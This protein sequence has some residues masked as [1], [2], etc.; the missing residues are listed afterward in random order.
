MQCD[1]LRL[2]MQTNENTETI[3]NI[4]SMIEEQQRLLDTLYK[5]REY[6]KNKYRLFRRFGV[7]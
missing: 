5:I 7:V 4:H 3:H 6:C 1:L 2:S